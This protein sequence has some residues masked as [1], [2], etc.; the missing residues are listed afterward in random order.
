MI[1]NGIIN[2]C[3]FLLMSIAVF[4]AIFNSPLIL[5]FVWALIDLKYQLIYTALLQKKEKLLLLFKKSS[6]Q[7]ITYRSTIYF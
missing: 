2:I 3:G 7:Q 4:H 5:K 1:F 6:D